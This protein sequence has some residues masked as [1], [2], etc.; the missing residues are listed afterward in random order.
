MSLLR[1]TTSFWPNNNV[2][3]ALC[4]GWVK[5]PKLSMIFFKFFSPSKVSKNDFDEKATFIKMADVTDFKWG[6]D[7]ELQWHHMSVH[8][9]NRNLTAQQL[10]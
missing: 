10:I 3:I 4:V 1:Q 9:N 7:K 5:I 2:I 8:P 6:C